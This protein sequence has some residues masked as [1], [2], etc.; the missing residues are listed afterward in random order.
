LQKIEECLNRFES[1]ILQFVD[2]A[3]RMF[4]TFCAPFHFC[5]VQS[6]VVS[7]KRLSFRNYGSLDNVF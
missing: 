5:S 7:E 3:A 1:E 4:I 2:I 6:Y